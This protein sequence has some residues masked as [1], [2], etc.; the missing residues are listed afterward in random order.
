MSRRNTVLITLLAAFVVTPSLAAGQT[1]GIGPRLSFVRGDI[2][3]ATPA[4]SFSGGTMRLST[5]PHIAIEVA[6][7]YRTK[8]SED[9]LQRMRE[10]P[11]QGS[12]L[13][14]LVRRTF[15]P[16]LLG[17][18][19]IYSQVTDVMTETPGIFVN[20]ERTRKTGVHLGFGAELFVSRHAAIFGDYRFRFVKFGQAASDGEPIHIPG[21]SVIPGLDKVKISHHGSMW[22]S[23]V[24]FYF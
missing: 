20:V 15:S 24:A 10:V 22:T 4:T 6:L 19:G 17:G 18:M 8:K 3:T 13:I 11:I 12:M 5:S 21:S 14:F 7:D 23:G 9:G 2:T 1:F 16:Y